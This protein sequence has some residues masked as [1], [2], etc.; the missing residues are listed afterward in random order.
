MS[1]VLGSR[2]PSVRGGRRGMLFLYRKGIDKVNK[3]CCCGISKELI[4]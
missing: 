4:K 3:G 1:G 2:G